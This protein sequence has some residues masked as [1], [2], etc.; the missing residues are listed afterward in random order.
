MKNKRIAILTSGLSRGSNFQAIAEFLRDKPVEINFL[1]HTRK[2]AP[3]VERCSML[4]VEPIF[5][6]TKDM[7]TF[8]NSLLLLAEMRNIKLIVLAGFT[9][10]LSSELLQDLQCPII[11]IHPALLPKYGGKGMYGGAAHEHVFRNKER[12]SGVTIHYV[13]ELYDHG[14]IIAQETVDIT[15]CKSPKEIAEKV[16][17]L[18]HS[19]YPRVILELLKD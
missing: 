3:I 12:E 8:E 4:G 16:L 6:S 14:E 10:K 2:K 15:D 19:L 11:N 7:S 13:D 1:V 18:E 9:R 17:K 5:L